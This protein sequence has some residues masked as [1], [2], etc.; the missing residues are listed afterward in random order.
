MVCRIL[1]LIWGSSFRLKGSFWY[2]WISRM[3]FATKRRLPKFT[4]SESSVPL[5]IA[6]VVGFRGRKSELPSST[7][8]IW[9]RYLKPRDVNDDG[10][11]SQSVCR[12]IAR[13][14]TA[15]RHM[16]HH[17][18][19]WSKFEGLQAETARWVPYIPKNGTQGGCSWLISCRSAAK[20]LVGFT[21]AAHFSMICIR[22][23]EISAHVSLSRSIEEIWSPATI[24]I[25]PA[26]PQHGI[27]ASDRRYTC[28]LAPNEGTCRGGGLMSHTRTGHE[29]GH[30]MRCCSTETARRRVRTMWFVFFWVGK[31][32]SVC[33]VSHNAPL[34][35]W[36]FRISR[37]ISRKRLT[38]STRSAKFLHSKTVRVTQLLTW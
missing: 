33:V 34:K 30:T 4:S 1:T 28:T 5:S 26:Y 18:H 35:F 22:F 36:R 7:C 14:H 21:S 2:C 3:I 11:I 25:T 6:S 32:E 10:K 13:T 37:R 9:V 31:G 12:N 15:G 29:R 17:K 19:L 38:H 16:G 27:A 20:F 24:S 8:R 23:G